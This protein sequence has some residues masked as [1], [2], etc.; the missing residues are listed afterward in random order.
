MEVKGGENLLAQGYVLFGDEIVFV[1]HTSAQPQ[2]PELIES[3][4]YDVMRALAKSS[5][6]KHLRRFQGS[7]EN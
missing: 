2:T 3:V 5:A 6:E 7:S 1:Q 4:A